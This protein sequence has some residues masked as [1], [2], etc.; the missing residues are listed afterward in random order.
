MEPGYEARLYIA[1]S[2]SRYAVSCCFCAA[3][4]LLHCCHFSLR[5]CC[6]L[7]LLFCCWA[8]AL[9][10][11]LAAFLLLSLTAFLLL[12]PTA[13]LLLLSLAA[14]LLLGSSCTA[15]AVLHSLKYTDVGS[16]DR[17]AIVIFVEC[18]IQH[19]GGK[20]LCRSFA[21]SQ[22]HDCNL[23]ASLGKNHPNHAAAAAAA[24]SQQSGP[25]KKLATTLQFVRF[26]SQKK[27]R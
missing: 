10:P 25:A 20:M 6:C 13:F 19:R 12:S 15:A 7:L 1:C 9:L 2:R 3:G 21:L 23:P 16:A 4:Q 24:L 11:L 27:A 18:A 14:F 26:W 17:I 8:A 5:F 22:V